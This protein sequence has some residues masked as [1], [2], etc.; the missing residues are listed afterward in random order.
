M[1]VFDRAGRVVGDAVAKA[2]E[3]ERVRL[4]DRLRLLDGLDESARDVVRLF[5]HRPGYSWKMDSEQPRLAMVS[6]AL[7][8]AD[9]ELVARV[10]V[11]AA[12]DPPHDGRT[13]VAEIEAAY[14]AIVE[15]L[16]VLRQETL[17][18]D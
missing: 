5:K 11:L 13:P 10:D 15:R 12:I 6:R 1:D 14:R 7:A 3:R 9:A 18:E 2:R 4:E 17:A 8:L 16:A